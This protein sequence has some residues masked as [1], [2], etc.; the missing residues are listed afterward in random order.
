MTGQVVL[1]IRQSTTSRSI[2]RPATSTITAPNGTNHNFPV[3]SGAGFYGMTGLVTEY[4]PTRRR[5]DS[6]CNTMRGSRI[7]VESTPAYNR[8][9]LPTRPIKHGRPSSLTRATTMS[10]SLESSALTMKSLRRT[11]TT[12]ETKFSLDRSFRV[13][14]AKHLLRLPNQRENLCRRCDTAL[15]AD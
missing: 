3:D 8:P 13:S 4:H 9:R 5:A 15:V 2:K 6:H 10:R 14:Q 7:Q 12:Y 1:Q 11:E